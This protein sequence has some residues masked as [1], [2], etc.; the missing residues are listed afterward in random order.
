[1]L[2]PFS[3]YYQGFF[4]FRLFPDVS[5][6]KVKGDAL[7]NPLTETVLNLSVFFE[8]KQLIYDK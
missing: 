8:L 7:H 5:N 1:M 2:T 4:I 6:V 3:S